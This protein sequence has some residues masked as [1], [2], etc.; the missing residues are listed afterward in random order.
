MYCPGCDFSVKNNAILTG[1][2]VF[3]T[4]VTKNNLDF[5]YDDSLP[6]LYTSGSGGG[7]LLVK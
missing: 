1:R 7:T 4:I 2:F 3:K 6:P 5:Y